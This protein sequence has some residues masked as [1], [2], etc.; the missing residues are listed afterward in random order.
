MGCTLS[1]ATLP[2]PAAAVTA[3]A[4][5]AARPL[6]ETGTQLDLADSALSGERGA[7]LLVEA[8]PHFPR[9]RT[10]NLSRC[11]LGPSGVL[12]M[13]AGLAKGV[14]KSLTSLNLS[15]TWDS[16]SGAVVVAVLAKSLQAGKLNHLASLNL[17]DNSVEG[18]G[19]LAL[20]AAL[21]AWRPPLRELLLADCHIGG[22]GCVALCDALQS[23]SPPSSSA[24]SRLIMDH[25]DLFSN[26]VGLAGATALGGTFR[27]GKVIFRSLSCMDCAFGPDGTRS[28]ASG[29]AS[30]GAAG[31]REELV[32]L[33]ISGCGVGIGSNAGCAGLVA[34]FTPPAVYPKLTYLNLACNSLSDGEPAALFVALGHLS[35]LT[36]LDLS[37][38]RLVAK[39]AEVLSG[40]DA[41]KRLTRLRTLGLND[42][43]RIGDH[44]VSH[45]LAAAADMPSLTALHLCNTGA[46]PLASTVALG[47]LGH[48][49]TAR[50]SMLDLRENRNASLID[51]TAHHALVAADKAIS[52]KALDQRE[53]FFKH[54][55]DSVYVEG[56]DEGGEL[57]QAPV[58]VG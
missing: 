29:F 21:K 37:S 39:D 19:A 57:N 49:N 41:M 6:L 58:R 23:L 9:L 53:M 27:S 22:S 48:E 15:G 3:L 55:G 52:T 18:A 34:A 8:P 32:H 44:A 50:L 1:K 20:A 43:E 33:D 47:L 26:M 36:W 13:A 5:A 7:R 54:V 16:A 2:S 40:R 31:A 14:P 17:S 46:G 51:A 12:T 35:N 56:H 4:D 25:L 28:F 38:N 30:A 11:A 24:S 45:M 42:N 10:L